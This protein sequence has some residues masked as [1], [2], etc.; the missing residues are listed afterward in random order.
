MPFLC[1]Y[2]VL[3]RTAAQDWD[4]LAM[5][6]LFF[7][8]RQRVGGAARDPPPPPFFFSKEYL[9]RWVSASACT[10]P[11]FFSSLLARKHRTRLTSFRFLPLT[12]ISRISYEVI[13]IEDNSPDG[14]LEVAQQLQVR[15]ESRRE[16]GDREE[17]LFVVDFR[18]C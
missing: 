1:D 3:L 4:C 5:S 17:G 18:F 13:I 6:P 8:P 11:C 15:Q 14:T 10:F 2:I 12:Y 9:V 7:F 16:E